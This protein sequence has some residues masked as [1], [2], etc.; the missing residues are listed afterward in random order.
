MRVN[1]IA[2]CV[3]AATLLLAVPAISDAGEGEKGGKSSKGLNCTTAGTFLNG[4]NTPVIVSGAVASSS[5]F[6]AGMYAR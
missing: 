3:A 4:D 1:K 5:G 6:V 2:C